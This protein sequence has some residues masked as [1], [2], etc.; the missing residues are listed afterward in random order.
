VGGNVLSGVQ[1]ISNYLKMTN[2]V[3][4]FFWIYR[5]KADSN[6]F[7]KGATIT[8]WSIDSFRGNKK[9][10]TF[11]LNEA[12]TVATSAIVGAALLIANLV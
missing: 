1:G 8:V 10:T 12:Y 6:F 7:S 3:D 2:N 5:N 9:T 4:N 11:V